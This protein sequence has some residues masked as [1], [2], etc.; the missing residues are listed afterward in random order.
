VNPPAP[1]PGASCR[2]PAGVVGWSSEGCGMVDMGIL[3]SRGGSRPSRV[4]RDVSLVPRR[5]DWRLSPLL[6][7]GKWEEGVGRGGKSWDNISNSGDSVSAVSAVDARNAC[8]VVIRLRGGLP[9]TEPLVV[10]GETWPGVTFAGF[11]RGSITTG[12]RRG[13]QGAILRAAGSYTTRPRRRWHPQRLTTGCF[14]YL[15]SKTQID[16]QHSVQHSARTEL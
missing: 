7:G 1:P 2:G 8:W 4:E 14:L 15:A 6:P 10:R 16:R 11:L 3:G 9:P 13:M 5:V 12:I